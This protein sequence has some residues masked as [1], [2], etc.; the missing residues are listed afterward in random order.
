M[1]GNSG[2]SYM[3]IDDSGNRMFDRDFFSVS[4]KNDGI[5]RKLN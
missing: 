5:G 2:G 4:I 1:V 3:F